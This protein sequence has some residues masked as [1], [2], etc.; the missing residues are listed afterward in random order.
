VSEHD[1]AWEIAQHAFLG[2]HSS[3]LEHHYQAESWVERLAQAIREQEFRS[4]CIAYECG[5]VERTD[6]DIEQRDWAARTIRR[7][8]REKRFIASVANS[9]Q[10]T[11]NEIIDTRNKRLWP[12]P[13]SPEPQ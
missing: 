5:L 9:L 12:K 8:R 7:L 6:R 2:I 11:L 13:E 10:S 4:I 3:T 1:R